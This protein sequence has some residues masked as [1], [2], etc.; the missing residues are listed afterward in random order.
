MN[1]APTAPEGDHSVPPTEG[2]HSVPPTEGDHVAEE[3]PVV[4]AEA[5]DVSPSSD[6]VFEAREVSEMKRKNTGLP[7]HGLRK[8]NSGGNAPGSFWI[9][10]EGAVT[11]AGASGSRGD[12]RWA[13]GMDGRTYCPTM[14]IVGIGKNKVKHC[15]CNCN[16][17]LH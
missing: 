13:K 8:G 16:Q 7:I 17:S 2:D 10:G 4:H 15:I 5:V 6:I 9:N 3:Q 12:Q 1:P 11:G 14:K